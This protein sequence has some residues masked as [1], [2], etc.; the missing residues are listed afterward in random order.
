LD[1]ITVG[2]D[3]AAEPK[4]TAIA[5]LDWSATGCQVVALRDKADDEMILAAARGADKLGIDAPI[6]WPDEFVAFVVAHRD[7]NVTVPDHLAGIDWRR[8]LAN[9]MTDFEVRR[10][11]PGL[12]PLSVST[13]RIA[14][15][16]MRAAGLLARLTAQ[17]RAV[18]RS[19]AGVIVEA[20]PAASLR[21]WNLTA[22][23]YKG[24][25]NLGTLRA[26]ARDLL[27]Q[28][29][30]LDLGEHVERFITSD[31]RFDAVIAGLTARAAALGLTHEPTT[32]QREIARREGWIAVPSGSLAELVR[33]RL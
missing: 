22:R 11:L 32:D 20:Y 7:G 18:D 33:K 17:G 27:A 3:L 8:Q 24:A 9:R 23:G 30:W 15:P 28:A 1:V 25:A 14:H 5:T 4:N 12:V 19:G 10:R 2:V 6:G 13:D 16:A 26:L 21:C 31:H 29:P